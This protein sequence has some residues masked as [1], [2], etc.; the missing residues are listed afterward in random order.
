MIM[1]GIPY[2][3][4]LLRGKLSCSQ[5]IDS[6]FFRKN[7]ELWDEFEHLY[8]TLFSN[9]EKYIKVVQTL[10]EKTGGL[11]RGEIAQ[12]SGMTAN[13]DLTKILNDLIS[14]GFVRVS[15]FY[16]KKKKDALYQLADYHTAFYFRYLKDHYGKMSISGAIQL[17][18]LDAGHGPVW[19]LNS[20][21]RIILRR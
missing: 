8:R 18:T 19:P 2:Y 11:T 7:G 15:G 10:S 3:L 14:C 9:N 4:N 20:S 16:K 21:A 13:G 6:L 12:K 17:I 5:N 1:G